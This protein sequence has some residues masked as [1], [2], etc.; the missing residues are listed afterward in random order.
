MTQI[1]TKICGFTRPEDAAAA[2]ELGIDA[3]GLVFFSGSKRCVSPQ[4]AAQI[5]RALPPFVT[6]VGLFV[7]ENA[8]TIERTLAQVPLDMLQFHGDETPE[9]CRRFNRPYLKAVRVQSREDIIQAARDYP[10]ARAL[11]LDAYRADGYGG[12]GHTFDW[13]MLPE[14]LPLPWILSG[15]LNT[16]NLAAAL[17]QT[18]A[19][20]IDISSGAESAPG[21]KSAEKIARLQNICI[22]HDSIHA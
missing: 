9:F 10:D 5:V 13:Q 6:V 21:I 20:S 11:L 22:Q 8:E 3:I 19:R 17:Q 18:G 2:A 4:Q 12:T 7:N 15:G 16:D 1:R 14:S